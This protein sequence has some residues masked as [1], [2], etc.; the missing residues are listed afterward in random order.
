MKAQ[1]RER[2]GNEANVCS[3]FS[4][5]TSYDIEALGMYAEAGLGMRQGQ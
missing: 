3:L 1:Q 5:T 2:P 4:L